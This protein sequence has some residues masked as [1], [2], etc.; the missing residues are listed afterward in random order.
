MERSTFVV[1][2]IAGVGYLVYAYCRRTRKAAR[3]MRIPEQKVVDGQLFPLVL[4]P[5]KVTDRVDF[6][7]TKREE[8]LVRARLPSQLNRKHFIS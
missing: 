2:A 4:A 1:A 3:S 6:A 7:R 8:I 5:N